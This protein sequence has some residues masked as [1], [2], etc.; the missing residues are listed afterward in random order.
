MGMSDTVE[1][2]SKPATVKSKTSDSLR[3]FRP[4]A[5][6]NASWEVLGERLPLEGF[7]PM[8]LAVHSGET[9]QDPFFLNFDKSEVAK[10]VNAKLE[11]ENAVKSATVIAKENL[12][13]Q[14]ELG[15]EQGYQKAKEEGAKEFEQQLNAE[16]E[17]VSE[18]TKSLGS[19][20]K[21]S[22]DSLE[23]RALELSLEVAKRILSA[24]A[25]LKPDYIVEVIKKGISLIGAS[26]PLKIKVSPQD[27]E[28]IKVVGLPAEISAS[29][30]GIEYQ[31]DEAISSGCIIETNYGS[32][33]LELD[34]MWEQVKDGIFEVIK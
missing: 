16:R 27:Y 25:E 5:Y 3:S 32:I 6:E 11:A 14:Y 7:A 18:L 28:F 30:L 24:T 2:T 17:K 29:E 19:E 15:F 8:K 20:V 10:E 33:N 34:S 22:M 23:Q 4:S 26:T 9:T 1:E 12:E 21:Q 31:A 13:K